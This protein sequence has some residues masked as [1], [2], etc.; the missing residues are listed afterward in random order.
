MLVL[1]AKGLISLDVEYIDGTKIES[2]ANKY[3]FVWRKTVERNRA[4][5]LRKIE[6]L[7]DQ[8]EDVIA[9]DNAPSRRPWRSPRHAHGDC[10]GT[11]QIARGRPL[12][13]KTKE[14]KQTAWEK[15]R[16]I[17]EIENSGTNFGSTTGTSIRWGAELVQQNGRGCDLHA[18]EGGCHEE[19]ADEAGLQPADS[20][21]A[22]VHHRLRTLRQPTDTLT[23]P[24]VP[25]VVQLTLRALCQDHGGR[26]RYGSEE[27]HLFMDVHGMD[28][29]VKYNYFHKEQRTRYTPTRSTPR[30]PLL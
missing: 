22:P 15:K 11:E 29:Y 20:H 7:L 28:A 8:V 5:L 27:N 6:A 2:K 18:H 21:R 16:Q 10:R 17:K 3:T 30:K 23:M 1:S 4:S 19:R 14:E 12:E 9:Q 26:L 13:P 25:G 24:L